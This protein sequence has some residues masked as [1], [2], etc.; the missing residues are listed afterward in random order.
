[1]RICCGGVVLWHGDSI[2]TLSGGAAGR[3][4]QEGRHRARAA[5]SFRRGAAPDEIELCTFGIA[6]PLVDYVCSA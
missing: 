2:A 1:M 3:V 5:S 6:L 4:A